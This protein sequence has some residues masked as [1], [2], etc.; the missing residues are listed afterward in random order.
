[1]VDGKTVAAIIVAGGSSSRMGFDKLL[2][3]LQ[4]KPVLLHSIQAMANNKYVDYL[5]LVV[6]QNRPQIEEMLA[7]QPPNKL[8]KIIQGG[9]TRMESVLAGVRLAEDAEIIAIHD[10][11]RP[12]VSDELITKGIE[13]AGETGAA[14]PGIAVKD[15]IKFVHNGKVEATPDRSLLRAVQTPQVF[16]RQA[17]CAAVEGIPPQEYSAIT[18][19]CMVFEKVGLPVAIFDGEEGNS[20]ITT[21]ADLP[22]PQEEKQN[23]QPRIGHGYDVHRLVE[24]REFILGGVNISYEKGLLGHSDG[25][26]LLHAITD[27]LFGALALGDIGT[28]FPDTDPAYKG[29]NSL[30]LLE[31]AAK[32]V[33][34]K[35]YTIGNVDATVLCQA[36]KLKSYIP[37]MITKIAVTLGVEAQGISVKATTEEGLGFTGEGLG[38]AAHCVVLLFPA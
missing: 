25:D 31:H 23:M 9:A 8:C 5:V 36:P 38:I 6:G 34:Q 18:D 15:T 4:G 3:P 32:I 17:Y 2:A 13:L 28:H 22:K 11:A 12:Y 33:K 19:D 10:G 26:V 14:A 24:G 21:P 27:A 37:A 1:M 7:Q 16:N 30:H 20:K 35:G 29:A